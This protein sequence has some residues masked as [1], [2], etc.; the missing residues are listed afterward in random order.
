V[1][2]CVC[3]AAPERW[4]LMEPLAV[5][6]QDPQQ[7]GA[8]GP[9]CDDSAGCAVYCLLS[10]YLFVCLSVCLSVCLFVCLS[11]CLFV[12][13]SVCLFVCLSVCLFVYCLQSVP[14]A[15]TVAAALVVALVLCAGAAAADYMNPVPMSRAGVS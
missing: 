14:S 2:V 4:V 11:V 13:L 3:A 7:H 8:K 15:V 9:W 10:I 6:P 5:M 12:C 1:C